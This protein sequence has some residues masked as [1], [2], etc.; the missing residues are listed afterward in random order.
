[1]PAN[2][3]T[4][5]KGSKEEIWLVPAF[6]QVLL[7]KGS[8][9]AFP[10]AANNS[11][12]TV[13]SG[14][15]PQT[16]EA[17]LHLASTRVLQID[18]ERLRGRE[19]LPTT[20]WLPQYVWRG[21]YPPELCSEEI[22]QSPSSLGKSTSTL[23]MPLNKKG[24]TSDTTNVNRKNRPDRSKR[25]KSALFQYFLPMLLHK[26]H[27]LLFILH[28]PYYHCSFSW[29]DYCSWCTQQSCRDILCVWLPHSPPPFDRLSQLD[30]IVTVFWKQRIG[31]I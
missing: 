24:W 27:H 13:T 14:D 2:K 5:H 1:M 19:D 17:Q 30:V 26:P 25:D 12:G 15:N 20:R 28:W 10:G 18:S 29:S 16:G 11:N 3:E 22:M 8:R 4:A 6:G 9:G 21:T 7:A 31:C 23:T